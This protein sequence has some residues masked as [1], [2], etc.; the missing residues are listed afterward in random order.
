MASLLEAAEDGDFSFL[1]EAEEGLPLG[2]LEDLPTTPT[3]FERQ[4]KRALE[5]APVEEAVLC[6]PNYPSAE[7]RRNHLRSRGSRRWQAFEKEFGEEAAISALAVLVKDETTGG[8]SSSS[9]Y[10]STPPPMPLFSWR[11]HG[12]VLVVHTD[13]IQSIL[14]PPLCFLAA[15]DHEHCSFPPLPAWRPSRS[16]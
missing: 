16:A 13:A 11:A 2:L 14:Q 4:T 6:K 8:S 5:G 1:L 15:H 12:V 10:Q 7:V 3:M 9:H